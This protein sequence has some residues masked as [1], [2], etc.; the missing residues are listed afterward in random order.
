MWYT[1]SPDGVYDQTE[2]GTR[3]KV[4][5]DAC[6]RGMVEKLAVTEHVWESH[7]PINWEETSVLER[8]RGQG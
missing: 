2:T 4:H 7:H 5:R 8:A 3:L 1:I 6:E